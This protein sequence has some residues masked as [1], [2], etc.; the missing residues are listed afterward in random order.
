MDSLDALEVSLSKVVQSAGNRHIILTGD[1]NLPSIDWVTSNVP[2]GA[3]DVNLCK[4]LLDIAHD[5]HLEQLVHE[6]TRYGP[7][8]ANTLDLVFSSKPDLLSD[9]QVIPGVSDHEQVVARIDRFVDHGFSQEREGFDFNK[10][11]LQD[12]CQDMKAFA[13]F[14]MQNCSQRSVHENW[15]I[16]KTT[17]LSLANKHYPV[18]ILKPQRKN[19]WF[20][21]SLR[22]AFRKKTSLI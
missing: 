18:K 7:T 6:P 4:R 1:F 13:A 17:I 10:G 11:N 9:I 8:S 21:R 20:D 5:F 3:K 14:F 19:Q 12:F 16:F 2:Y 15:Q 22:R